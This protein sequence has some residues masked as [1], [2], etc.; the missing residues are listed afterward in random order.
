M[1]KLQTFS[2]QGLILLP[3]GIGQNQMLRNSMVH[4]FK[5]RENHAV[6]REGS[7]GLL[8]FHAIF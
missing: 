6:T 8:S 2:L 3:Y 7:E 5:G 1:F 4:D